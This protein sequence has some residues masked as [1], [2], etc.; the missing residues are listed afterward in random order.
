LRHLQSTRRH[1]FIKQPNSDWERS[2]DSLKF[3]WPDSNV[4]AY[5]R[6]KTQEKKVKISLHLFET[7]HPHAAFQ[8]AF[9]QWTSVSLSPRLSALRATMKMLLAVATSI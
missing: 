4:S 7:H 6:H 9:M 2:A 3:A 1:N 5:F 8:F